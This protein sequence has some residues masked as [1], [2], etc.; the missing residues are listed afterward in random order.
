MMRAIQVRGRRAQGWAGRDL[1]WAMAEHG[2]TGRHRL[3]VKVTAQVLRQRFHRG[4]ALLG[5]LAQRLEDDVVEVAGQLA[6]AATVGQRFAFLGAP[7]RHLPLE[8]RVGVGAPGEDA[9]REVRRAVLGLDIV[10]RYCD[11]DL[12]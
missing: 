2:R 8:E 4:V 7:H 6:R 3:A 11:I 9:L 12:G 5:F 10:A 1:W